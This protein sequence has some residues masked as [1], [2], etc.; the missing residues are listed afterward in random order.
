MVSTTVGCVANL[1]SR[2]LIKRAQIVWGMFLIFFNDDFI[3]SFGLVVGANI[4]ARGP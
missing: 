1:Q 3:L 2:Q 4:T